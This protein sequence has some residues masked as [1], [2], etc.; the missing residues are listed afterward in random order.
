MEKKISVSNP[1]LMLLVVLLLP[2]FI[3]DAQD[4]KRSPNS[5]IFDVDYARVNNYGGILIPVKKA[6]KVWDD[7]EGFLNSQIPAGIQSA[8]VYW[9]DVP[10][11]IKEVSISGEGESAQIK[12][13]VNKGKSKGN[14]VISFHVGSEGNHNDPIYWS[15]HI[16]VTDD[17]TN[18]V[19]YTK[20]FETDIDYDRFDPIFMDRNL[21]AV[22]A[23]FL[24]NGWNKSTGLFYQWGR[25]DPIPPL[26]HKDRSY[27]E[28]N[29]LAGHITDEDVGTNGNLHYQMVNRPFSNES[30]N[31]KYSIQN[32]LH[33]LIAQMGETWFSEQVYKSTEPTIAWDLW[34][35]N[36]AGGPSN[37]NSSNPDLSKDSKSYEL[38]SVYDPCPG[39]WRITSNYGREASNNNLSPYGRGG[40]GDDDKF[41]N[42]ADGQFFLDPEVN[43]G[44]PNSTILTFAVNPVLNGIKV[45]PKLG[46]DFR[47]IPNRNMGLF[48]VNGDF[49]MYKNNGVY[50]HAIYQD[51]LAYGGVWSATYGSSYPRF[52]HFI[53]DADQV[54]NGVGRYMVRINDISHTSVA[55]GVR[56]IKDPNEDL[57]G[58]FGTNYIST[59]EYENYTKG[60]K[61]PNSYLVENTSET[62]EIPVNKA[63]SVYNQHLNYGGNLAAN[64][65]KANVLWTTNVELI[66][67]IVIDYESDLRDSKIRIKFKNEE[68]GNAVVSLHNGDINNPVYWSWHIWVPETPVGTISYTTEDTLP[69][70]EHIINLTKSKYPPL[71]THFMDRNLGALHRFPTVSDPQNPS[72]EE[73]LRINKSAGFNYQWGRKDPLPIFKIPGSSEEYVI[74]RGI[75]VDQNGS[76]LYQTMT[77]ADY[78]SFYTEDYQNYSVIA[79]AQE[80]DTKYEKA[81]KVLEYAARNPLKFLYHPG[82]GVQFNDPTDIDYKEIRDWLSDSTGQDGNRALMSERWGHADE[83]SVFDPCP[84]GWRVPDYSVVLLKTSGKGTSPWYF[85]NNGSNGVDQRYAFDLNNTYKAQTVK[86]GN[87]IIGWNFDY[88][89]FKIGNFPKTAIRGELGGDALSN[90]TA[91]WTAALSDYMLGFGLA[92]MIQ[93]NEKLRTGTA[94]Y[95]QA[96]LNVRCAKDEPRYVAD[97]LYLDTVEI[98]I[99]DDEVLV[100]YPNPVSDYLNFSSDE[101]F[102]YSVLYL[103]GRM[104]DKGIVK[105][106]RLDFRELNKGIYLLVLDNKIVRKIIKN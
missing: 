55:K 36:T 2:F 102:E 87:K 18:G 56:C 53:A 17:P 32:P 77:S 106:S 9:E 105:N 91:V 59:P 75:A 37:A 26:L 10:E 6:Y 49:V 83:K 1:N 99:N 13:V 3:L 95:P 92:M 103:Y 58:V 8:A 14:A 22:N 29:G 7:T 69:S 44:K 57:I 97:Q 46:L 4:I 31:I 86:S 38:K 90:N 42:Y 62:L 98:E 61:N 67:S 65:L 45:Y 76:V 28:L 104:I 24:G 101:N 25:K 21:G 16:W 60:L 89:D 19:E 68:S 78:E 79:G 94:I 34:S 74:Y 43:G 50:T 54:D 70:G 41:N 85:G 27:Y 72:Q 35:D 73:M 51:E 81:S 15:W 48:P 39:G 5:Y 96:A 93:S 88:E 23:H 66:Q 80:A 82:Q 100:I 20:G 47:E 84:E 30:D 33:Y 64:N 71:E 52:F 63:F 11:L 40:G 12:V